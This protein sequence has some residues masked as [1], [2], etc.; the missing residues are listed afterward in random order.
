LA[1]QIRALR[2][3]RSQTD[4]GRLIDKPQSVVSRLEDDSYGRLTLNTLLDVADK[5]DIAL[6]VQFTNFSTFLE[7]AGDLPQKQ[8]ASTKFSQIEVERFVENQRHRS[9]DGALAAFLR[10]SAEHGA[11]NP[12]INR[13]PETAKLKAQNVAL[14]TSLGKPAS[15]WLFEPAALSMVAN[16]SSQP[17]QLIRG[18]QKEGK[19]A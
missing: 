14:S 4:F 13:A 19:V 5:L 8:L 17:S 6:V 18:Q 16:E 3:D 15:S 11:Q 7:F 2:G 1:D 9:A 12:Q 10:Q